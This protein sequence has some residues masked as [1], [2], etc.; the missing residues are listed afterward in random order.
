MFSTTALIRLL[1]FLAF[2]FLSFYAFSGIEFAKFYQ[3]RSRQKFY[4]FIFLLCL[5]TAW[6][7]T[8]ALLSFTIYGGLL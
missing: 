1:V 4:I 2:F 8:E 7:A 6:L 3:I 5:I